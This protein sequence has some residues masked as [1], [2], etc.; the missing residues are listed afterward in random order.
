MPKGISNFQTE[1]PIKNL[2]D[3]TMKNFV[4]VFPAKHMNKSINLKL[5]VSER[6]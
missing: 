6:N 1:H 2:E 4:G 5:M 3:D